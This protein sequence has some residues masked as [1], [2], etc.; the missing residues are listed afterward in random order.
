MQK[1]VDGCIQMA[2][3]SSL[4][5]PHLRDSAAASCVMTMTL[6]AGLDFPWDFD[7]PA[8]T[9]FRCRF[10]GYTVA[11]LQFDLREEEVVER[12][13]SDVGA[14]SKMLVCHGLPWCSEKYSV[15]LLAVPATQSRWR[16]KPH[17]SQGPKA[18]LGW[19]A[20]RKVEQ[21]Q[22]SRPGRVRRW[23]TGII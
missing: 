16:L 3:R 19:D 18:G 4:G 17:C 14:W 8:A 10:C 7:N 13:I 12:D 6:T 21:V 20:L 11:D 23:Y 5:L 9:E 2:S 22:F 15:N 1:L